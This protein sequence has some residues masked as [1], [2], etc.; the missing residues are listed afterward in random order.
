MLEECETMIGGLNKGE[1]DGDGLINA[2]GDKTLTVNQR[3]DDHYFRSPHS[4]TSATSS[5]SSLEV[6]QSAVGSTQVLFPNGLVINTSEN[7]RNVHDIIQGSVV[8]SS[9]SSDDENDVIA[10]LRNIQP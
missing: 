1:V 3:V 9:R 8:S 7:V 5:G 4:Q 2:Q 6:V 10:L